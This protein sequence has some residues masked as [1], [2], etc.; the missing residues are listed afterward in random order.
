MRWFIDL[1]MLFFPS[2][3]LICGKRLDLPEDI[4]CYLCEIKMPRTVF[5]DCERN[6]VSKIFWG[7]ARV[8]GGTSLFKFE[9]GSSCQMLLHHLKYRGNRRAGLYLGRL[10]GQELMQTPLSEC[11]LMVPVPLHRRRLRQRGYNQSELIARGVSEITGIPLADHLIKRCRYQGSQ[12][13]MN[14]QERFENMAKAFALCNFTED[15]QGKKILIIDDIVTTG[16]TLEVCSQ[17]LTS[18]FSCA[19]HI[20]TIAYA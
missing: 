5:G 18:G 8:L 17:L 20:A 12:T 1:L 9:K 10:L 3:C 14:R 2:N 13:S 6:P 4:L 15:L 19:I 7:R 11:D 16:A